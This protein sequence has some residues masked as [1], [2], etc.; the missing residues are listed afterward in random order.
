MARPVGRA[1][2]SRLKGLKAETPGSA[3]AWASVLSLDGAPVARS[4]GGRPVRQGPAAAGADGPKTD[5]WH[6]CIAQLW[7][8]LLSLFC[9]TAESVEIPC[10][11]SLAAGKGALRNVSAD[12]A[13]G[14]SARIDD[15][16]EVVLYAGAATRRGL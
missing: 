8:L 5:G 15:H 16:D 14:R 13:V 10:R 2:V 9:N 1:S 4:G 6:S 3:V 11:T 12:P 7:R